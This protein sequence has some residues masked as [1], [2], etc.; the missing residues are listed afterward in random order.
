MIWEEL[1]LWII[2]ELVIISN[3]IEYL[4]GNNNNPSAAIWFTKQQ[5]LK[6]WD[7]KRVERSLWVV[8]MIFCIY[9]K[10]NNSSS[11]YWYIWKIA[12]ITTWLFPCHHRVLY[13]KGKNIWTV[14]WYSTTTT[15]FRGP[16]ASVTFVSI[17]YHHILPKI[18]T[19]GL[20]EYWVLLSTDL[21]HL[22][23]VNSIP[24]SNF[25]HIYVGKKII[26]MK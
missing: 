22:Q 13:L 2:F 10:I 9:H 14:C 4:M 25:F 15:S 16:C 17:F 20:V 1:R 18:T 12:L 19:P 23:L 6:F 5:F 26:C 7:L 21:Y 8:M 24:F 3:I 11:W